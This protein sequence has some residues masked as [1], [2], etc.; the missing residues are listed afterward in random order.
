MQEILDTLAMV[1]TTV[2]T[3]PHKDIDPFVLMAIARVMEGLR[4]YIPGLEALSYQRL[5]ASVRLYR[6]SASDLEVLASPLHKGRR[7][8]LLRR[9]L[10]RALRGLMFSPHDPHLWYNVAGIY[11]ER[12]EVHTSIVVLEHILWIH[13]GYAQA[14]S[15]LNN[16]RA[17]MGH[18]PSDDSP[19][20]PSS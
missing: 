4:W 9:S 5:R 16:L 7:A 13:P 2:Q 10:A 8:K 15:D 19:F 1:S 12:G 20:R 11:F 14:R 17:Y 3:R 18:P 6:D